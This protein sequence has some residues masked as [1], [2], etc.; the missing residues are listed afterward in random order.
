MRAKILKWEELSW[1]E[2][3]ELSTQEKIVLIPVGAVEQ[4]GPHNP[5]GLDTMVAVEI[6]ER[7]AEKVGAIM[8]PPIYYG[9]SS[10]LGD[11]PGTITLRPKT[12]LNIL[13]DIC[14]SLIELGFNKIVFVNG[15]GGNDPLLRLVVDEMTRKGVMVAAASWW[16]LAISE[17]GKIREVESISAH[18]EEVETSLILATKYGI[19]VKME[20]AIRE[21]SEVPKYYK[22]ALAGGGKIMVKWNWRL[23]K[24]GI[25]AGD[26]T[27][28]TK[29][30]GKKML[31]AVV[32]NLVAFLREIEKESP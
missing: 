12:V 9:E 26:A 2:V 8:L 1:P 30:K 21:Y 28:A 4:H 15:H 20:N 22:G 3:E 29:E 31:E 11:W 17:I 5:T 19:L 24:S 27:L 18:A 10:I 14:N 23:S 25:I 32:N 16:S 7:V 6:A 13:K